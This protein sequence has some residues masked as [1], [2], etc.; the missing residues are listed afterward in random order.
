MKREYISPELEMVQ[1]SL[2]DVLHPSPIE[3]DIPISGNSDVSLPDDEL[4]LP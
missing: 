2:S 4:E 1:F 3:G